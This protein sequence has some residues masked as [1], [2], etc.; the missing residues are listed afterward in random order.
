MKELEKWKRAL[1]A[2]KGKAVIGLTGPIASGKS[3]ALKC[4]IEE[5]ACG[6]S[7]DAVSEELLTTPRIYHTI[8]KKF[9]HEPIPKNGFPDKEKLAAEVFRSP[10]KRKWLEGLLHPEILKRIHA[11]TTKS[12]KRIVIVEAPLL[13]EAGL[14]ECFMLT[15]CLAAPEKTLRARAAGR[16]WSAAQYRSR[17]LAQ[18]PAGRKMELA[19]LVLDNSGTPRE[20]KEKIK[21]ICRF[22]E[23]TG[24][25][26]KT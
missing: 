19:D 21:F 8:L 5:G 2:V 13:F 26:K 1:K 4:F 15:V 20:L 12:R 17:V 18:L 10:A 7:A 6:I 3:L 23:E 22:L 9:A 25:R 11:L 24:W 14:A 16:G